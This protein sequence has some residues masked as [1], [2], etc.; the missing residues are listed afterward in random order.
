[1]DSTTS[2][3]LL[4]AITFLLSPLTTSYPS[5]VLDALHLALLG[6]FSHLD[7]VSRRQTFLLSPSAPPPASIAHALQSTS[8]FPAE[9][10]VQW[11][12]WM[13]LLGGG[14]QLVLTIALGLVQLAVRDIKTG[15][16]RQSIIWNASTQ[17]RAPSPWGSSVRSRSSAPSSSDSSVGSESSRSSS[18]IIDDIVAVEAAENVLNGEDELDAFHTPCVGVSMNHLTP[19]TSLSATAPE[20]YPSTT[21]RPIH[22]KT[23][24]V[25]S[26][27]TPIGF[28]GMPN[29]MHPIIAKRATHQ[30]HSRSSSRS[31]TLSSAP[32]L[33]SSYSSNS[34]SAGTINTSALS[35]SL[36]SLSLRTKTPCLASHSTGSSV[37]SIPS[38]AVVPP[39]PTPSDISD[40]AEST[41]YLDGS[42]DQQAVTEYECGKVGVLTGAVML[43]VPKGAKAVRVT[44]SKGGVRR[45]FARFSNPHQFFTDQIVQVDRAAISG[46]TPVRRVAGRLNGNNAVGS[47]EESAEH[48]EEG[49]LDDNDN[50]G[51]EGTTLREVQLQ[52]LN[53][54]LR[55]SLQ[56]RPAGVPKVGNK[57]AEKVRMDLFQEDHLAAAL[58]ESPGHVLVRP[59]EDT[60]RERRERRDRI[61]TPGV[62]FEI[63]DLMKEAEVR[64]PPYKEKLAET[65]IR[66]DDAHSCARD[67]PT[68]AL[69]ERARLR[70]NLSS[71]QTPDQSETQTTT[72]SVFCPIIPLTPQTSPSSS[73]SPPSAASR[74]PSC[75][76]TH[77]RARPSHPPP[78]F[79]RP[80]AEWGG[81][82]RGY[83]LGWAS[84]KPRLPEQSADTPRSLMSRRV[85]KEYV[86]DAMGKG[87]PIG[88]E[89]LWKLPGGA[90]KRTDVEGSGRHT[91]WP[92]EAHSGEGEHRSGESS[93]RIRARNRRR[94]T[95]ADASAGDKTTSA[96]HDVSA[97]HA[98]SENLGRRNGLPVPGLPGWHGEWTGPG[99][100]LTWS[101]TIDQTLVNR[102][103]DFFCW[104]YDEAD[105]VQ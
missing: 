93:E 86:R 99:E 58:H 105:L 7:I 67:F 51:D 80:E 76:Q 102:G 71:D 25:Q 92:E 22:A 15:D 85:S 72:R 14:N 32:S 26:M 78:R 87:V 5:P 74:P 62:V 84:S 82:S 39:S 98:A 59:A 2:A 95:D 70:D 53:D 41:F 79:F 89:E 66:A 1:M 24:S 100:S 83:A 94:E 52:K 73:P 42:K 90:W 46:G 35:A 38:A 6:S 63:H 44:G 48:T 37:S 60:K 68:L 43:G 54:A 91:R 47:D 34:S 55:A 18:P 23:P 103:M 30:L 20:W 11:S 88:A 101:M 19:R 3:T 12:D 65:R 69:T 13:L 4:H 10:R 81:K 28:N 77:R 104:R 75:R 96:I 64:W 40:T 33:I 50:F 16:V 61:H 45:V 17:A 56:F 97:D 57:V 21:V 9:Y 36:A 8:A 31:S 27:P 49:D 29:K